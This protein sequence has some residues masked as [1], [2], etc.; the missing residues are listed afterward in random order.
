MQARENKKSSG[1][2]K[3]FNKMMMNK[4]KNDFNMYVKPGASQIIPLKA[5]N[6]D[7]V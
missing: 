5:C 6:F 7:S 4:Q 2:K 1:L 3:G